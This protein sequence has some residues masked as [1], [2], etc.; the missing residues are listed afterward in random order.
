[1]K[2][3]EYVTH[4]GFGEFERCTNE[5]HTLVWCPTWHK[6][7]E[8]PLHLCTTHAQLFVPGKCFWGFRAIEEFE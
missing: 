2:Q 6:A 4:A 8:G 7:N 3:C 5:V 1:M